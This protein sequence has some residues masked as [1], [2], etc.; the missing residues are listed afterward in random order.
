MLNLAEML[1]KFGIKLTISGILL[2]FVVGI[3]GAVY[4]DKVV[5]YLLHSRNRG[6]FILAFLYAAIDLILSRYNLL[7][8][9]AT[10][11]LLVMDIAF[12]VYCSYLVKHSSFLAGHILKI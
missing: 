8:T 12:V 4:K 6:G 7:S 9:A 1:D 11:V 5:T 2:L 3:M 10:Y